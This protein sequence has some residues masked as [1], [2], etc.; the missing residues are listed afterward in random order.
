MR[1]GAPKPPIRLAALGITFLLLAGAT[2]AAGSQTQGPSAPLDTASHPTSAPPLLPRPGPIDTHVYHHYPDL[3]T[4]LQDLAAGH[5]DT[6]KL[7]SIGKSVQGR[8]LW[9]M[10]VTD[11]SAQEGG[12]STIYI[13]GGHH[14]NEQL[15]MELAVLL[16]HEAAEGRLSSPDILAKTHFFIVPM[17]NPDGNMMDQR[18]NANGVDLNRNYAFQWTN[19]GNH[20]SGPESE[21]ESH[22]NA[23][24]MRAIDASFGIDLYLTGHTGTNVLIYSWAWTLDKAPDDDLLAHIGATANNL[25]GV[26]TGQTSV[27]LYIATGSSKDFGYGE[28]GAPSFTYEVD[29]QQTRLGTYTTTIAG[30]LTDEVNVC[31]LLVGEAKFMRADIRPTSWVNR[32][33]PSG[34]VVAVTLEN[35]GWASAANATA[36]LAFTAGGGSVPDPTRTFSLSGENTTTLEFPVE[37]G[38]GRFNLSLSLNYPEMLVNNSTVNQSVFYGVLTVAPTGLAAILQGG[39]GLLLILLLAVGAAVVLEDRFGAGR[40]RTSLGRLGAAS[41]PI[42]TAAGRL[43]FRRAPP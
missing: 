17:V 3:T 6:V 12:K 4:E 8:E 1:P 39:G 11:F 15:G 14:G 33:T 30:R 29:N 40:L 21:P 42:R 5:P 9:Q 31:I 18:Q 2:P 7:T 27:L 43:K 38:G 35:R 36:T 10:E 25:T 34:P 41:G 20:G 22:A 24:N 28:L 16:I 19:E 26:T 32:D 13:D 23:D 37:S